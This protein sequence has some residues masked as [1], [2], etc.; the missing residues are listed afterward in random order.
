MGTRRLIG[1]VVGLS[2]V[3]VVGAAPAV[4]AKGPTSARIEGPGV[5]APVKVTW[6]DDPSGPMHILVE[7]TEAFS[8]GVR[9]LCRLAQPPAGELG[10]RYRLS[11][12]IPSAAELL[13]TSQTRLNQDFYPD[14]PGGPLTYYGLSGAWMRALPGV[15]F[16]WREITEGAKAARSVSVAGDSVALRG[17]SL[18]ATGAITDLSP[19]SSPHLRFIDESGL[20]MALLD[21]ASTCRVADPPTEDLGPRYTL[22]WTMEDITWATQDV[23]PFAAGGPVVHDHPSRLNS[24]A[25]GGWFRADA[26]LLTLWP[27]LGLPTES[28]AMAAASPPAAAVAPVAATRPAT[29]PAAWLWVFAAAAVLAA[30]GWLGV[31]WRRHGQLLADRD[32]PPGESE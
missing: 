30:G 4:Y 27:K 22:T 24:A 3:V 32:N 11:W 18:N 14:A 16:W 19:E 6:S 23:Y 17:A 5:A 9:E 28:Q 2:A 1:V 26:A 7:A 10:P 13:G 29:A 31:R 20:S 21:G 15:S 12:R 8:L 25:I